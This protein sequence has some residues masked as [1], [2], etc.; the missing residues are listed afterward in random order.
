MPRHFCLLLKGLINHAWGGKC[1]RGKEV[2]EGSTRGLVLRDDAISAP[3]TVS[4]ARVHKLDTAVQVTVD[5]AG[6]RWVLT[7]IHTS[8]YTHTHAHPCLHRGRRSDLCGDWDCTIFK[9][10]NRVFRSSRIIMVVNTSSPE[11]R[12]SSV[13][14]RQ[15]QVQVAHNKVTQSRRGGGSQVNHQGL[16]SRI[17]YRQAINDL[18]LNQVHNILADNNTY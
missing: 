2:W 6:D 18:I 1:R 3:A 5:S 4:A 10:R 8:A 14:V 16:K 17:I 7:H 13:V 15:V 12:A 11:E 9:V